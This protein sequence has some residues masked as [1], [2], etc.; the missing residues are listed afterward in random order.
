MHLSWHLYQEETQT[1]TQG[2]PM[3]LQIVLQIK[4]NEECKAKMK[5]FHS[6]FK[7]EKRS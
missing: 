6:P 5:N 2:I 4:G 7:L 3:T 1:G